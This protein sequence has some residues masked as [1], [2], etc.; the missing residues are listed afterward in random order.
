M[1]WQ[2]VLQFVSSVLGSERILF[3]TDYPYESTKDAAQFIES[4]QIDD[5]D[6]ELICHLNAEK[7]L[8]L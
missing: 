6:K 1:F 8:R 7:L 4:V 3:A 2:P 5:G